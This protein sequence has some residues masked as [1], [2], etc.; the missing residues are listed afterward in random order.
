MARLGP[1]ALVLALLAGTAAAFIVTETLKTSPSPILQTRVDKVFSPVCACDRATAAITFRLRR[2]DTVTLTIEDARG[3]TVRVLV[4]SRRVAAG[5]HTWAWDGRR[6]DGT[7]AADA[8]YRPRVELEDADRTL[9]LPNRIRLDT[10]PPRVTVVGEPQLGG[11]G[12]IV[13][14]YTLDEPAKGLLTVDGTRVARTYRSRVDTTLRVAAGTLRAVG[15]TRGA[16]ALAAE[17]TAGNVS[18]A[19]ALG[20]RR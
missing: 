7:V 1:I 13:V 10:V 2:D 9:L 15:A 5:L 4:P 3:R 16:V 6:E 17:D 11:P 8:S 19:V 18:E 12:P 14:R 20:R